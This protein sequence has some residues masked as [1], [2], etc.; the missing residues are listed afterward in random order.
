MNM[1][2]T[3]NVELMPFEPIDWTLRDEVRPRD[4]EAIR[5][6]VARTGFFR[7]D[8]I[9]VAVELVDER[10]A[11]GELSGYEFLMAESSGQLV[12]YA[13]Y[14]PIACTLGSYDL[15]WIAV[16]PRHQRH[17]LGRRLVRAVESRVAAD[18]GRQIFVDTSGQERYAPTR[19]FYERCGYKLAARLPGFYAPGDDKLIYVRALE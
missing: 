17:G 4:V 14:G 18:G 15:Y 7:T 10:L 5:G 3:G 6:L 8:E 13:C 19:A 11:K 16:D 12:G 2:G 1:N 9:E